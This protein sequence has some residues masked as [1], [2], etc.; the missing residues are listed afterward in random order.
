MEAGGKSEA[1]VAMHRK[2]VEMKPEE[3]IKRLKFE[4]VLMEANHR[5]CGS[6][7]CDECGQ[8]LDWSEV[9]E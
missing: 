8:K 5:G 1:L 7:Y 6:K 9:E 2:A 4:T 3:A